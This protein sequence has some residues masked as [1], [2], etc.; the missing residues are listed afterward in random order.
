MLLLEIHTQ[1]LH[2]AKPR[3]SWLMKTGK[4][5]H[6]PHEAAASQDVVQFRLIFNVVSF[7]S[8][9]CASQG[10]TYSSNS[11]KQ[12]HRVQLAV[13]NLERLLVCE[14]MQESL[15]HTRAPQLQQG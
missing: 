6:R 2:T 7:S 4:Q 11:S 14:Q 3:E 5:P 8:E 1:V 9:A 12:F 15:R 13:P 10:A